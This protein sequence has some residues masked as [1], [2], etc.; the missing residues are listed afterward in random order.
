MCYDNVLI[1]LFV[2]WPVLRIVF[3]LNSKF[4]LA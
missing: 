2:L 3:V 4:P 1:G